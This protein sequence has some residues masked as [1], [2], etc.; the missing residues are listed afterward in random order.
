[1]PWGKYERLLMGRERNAFELI[2][3]TFEQYGLGAGIAHVVYGAIA[4]GVTNTDQLLELVRD[5][6]AYKRRFAGMQGRK[7]RPI[8][9]AEY[10]SIEEGYKRALQEAGL[11][12]GFYDS[13]NDF[14]KWIREDRSPSEVQARIQA[15][16]QVANAINP[17][18]RSLLRNL[19]GVNKGDLTAYILNANKALPILQ[20]QVEAAGIGAAAK[21]EGVLGT[22]GADD[23]E[24]LVE[25]GVTAEQARQ[26]FATVR[27]FTEQLG[28][29]AGIYGEDFTARDA[30]R[31]VFLGDTE[32]RRGLA[33]KE[34]ATFGGSS[35]GDLGTGSLD[36]N[37]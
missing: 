3:R 24:Y 29:V 5:S 20:R 9:E 6:D 22:R 37:L 21:K 35:R 25:A 7:G 10:I 32:K 2:V 34:R 36:F 18:Q 16:G 12:K 28:R 15:A 14:A 23:F 27:D 33:S 11:P 4:N 1:M 13:P 8:T 31:D 26:Q 17:A 19:W 30:E